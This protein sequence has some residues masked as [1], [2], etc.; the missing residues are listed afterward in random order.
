MNAHGSGGGT[1]PVHV[2]GV[3]ERIEPDFRACRLC[4]TRRPGTAVMCCFNRPALEHRI[5]PLVPRAT[6]VQPSID[7]A[8]FHVLE[9]DARVPAP[10]FRNHGLNRHGLA[11]NRTPIPG[12]RFIHCLEAGECAGAEC[13][14]LQRPSGFFEGKRQY[15][16]SSRGF[17]RIPEYFGPTLVIGNSGRDK[18][19]IG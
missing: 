5:S 14:Q 9:P 12:G 4:G 6:P 8:V 1:L 3:D 2:A 16:E 19:P 18:Q 13:L 11:P 17:T 7:A 15:L 10:C